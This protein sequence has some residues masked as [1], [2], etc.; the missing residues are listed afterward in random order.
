MKNCKSLFTVH[1]LLC[2]V[3]VILNGC[4]GEETDNRDH[5]A[6][7]AAGSTQNEKPVILLNAAELD[8][9][10]IEIT[11]AAGG[12]LQIQRKL[13]GEIVIPP[14]HLAHIVPRFPGI[15]MDVRKHIGDSVKEG[16]LL[17]IIESNESLAK[18]EVKSLIAGTV[19]DKHLSLGEVITDNSHAFTI[20]DLSEVW[21]H[22][23]LYQK[24]L[25]Y[26]RLQQKVIISAGPD[27]PTANGRI[28]YIS[29]LLEETTRTATARV[30]L[31]NPDGIWRPGLF[32]NA[33][34][35]TDAFAAA[36]IIPKT[37]V[38]TINDQPVIFVQT[39]AGF[40]P[41]TV[42]LGKQ[43]VTHFEVLSGLAAGQRF[44]AKG[45]FILKAEL[46]KGSFASGHQH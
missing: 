9:F 6:V 22:L 3:G 23:S 44:V 13:F 19:T 31:K 14:D 20:T 8:E 29:P 34:V 40:E 5:T 37:A 38:E 24:D 21:V 15:V 28:S 43:S 2:L 32:I 7:N 42:R 16:E 17:A 26:I 45:G 1:T 35:E 46:A 11:T 41:K 33:H 4:T 10:G 25:P 27:M 12:H 30:E 39:P 36:L 18:Y